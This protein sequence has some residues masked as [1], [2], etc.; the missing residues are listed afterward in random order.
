MADPLK[1][2]ERAR[3]RL[4]RAQKAAD[5]ARADLYRSF[6]G[7]RKAGASLSAIGRAAGV[8]RQLVA[9]VL[10]RASRGN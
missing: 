1:D 9:Q 10:E 3:V 5:V 7:A 8:S 4:E 2:V 6:L